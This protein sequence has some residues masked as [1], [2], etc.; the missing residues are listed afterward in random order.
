MR[1][2]V[3]LDFEIE[4]QITIAMHDT[5]SSSLDE[6]VYLVL[7]FNIATSE[8]WSSYQ[9][10]VYLS[11]AVNRSDN[12]W[13]EDEEEGGGGGEGGGGRRRGRRGRRE[14]GRG[15]SSSSRSSRQIHVVTVHMGTCSTHCTH[16][17][18]PCSV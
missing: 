6:R 11:C 14:R 12:C 17:Y 13:R 8:H 1:D 10:V 3:R 5:V 2:Y 7:C 9:G 16:Y 4:I 15:R 18:N